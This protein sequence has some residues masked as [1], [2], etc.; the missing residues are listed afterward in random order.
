[1]I[2]FLVNA[3]GDHDL[4]IPREGDYYHPLT[5]VYRTRL[6]DDVRQL[7][8]TKVQAVFL[9]VIKWQDT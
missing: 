7:V 1:M 4:A 5:A 8:K 6:E 9:K 3:L 2:R